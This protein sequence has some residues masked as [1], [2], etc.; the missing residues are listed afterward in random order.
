MK[1]QLRITTMYAFIVVDD[2]G[3]EGVPAML[4]PSGTFANFPMLLPLMG[5]DLDR[6]NSL[7]EYVQTDPALK[8]K[9]ITLAKFSVRTN[10]ETITR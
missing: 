1:G 7:R 9:T 10:L 5:A 4:A 3:T 6:V 2:D 8:G